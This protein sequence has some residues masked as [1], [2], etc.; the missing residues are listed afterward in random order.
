MFTDRFVKVPSKIFNAKNKELTGNE[1]LYDCQLRV[2]PM[3]IC[4]YYENLDEDNGSIQVLLKNG[5][6]FP[7]YLTIQEFEKLLNNHL[8]SYS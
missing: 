2:L 1:E 7:V 3:E 5:D 6:S 8:N 4:E